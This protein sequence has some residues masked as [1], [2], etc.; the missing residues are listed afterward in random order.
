MHLNYSAGMA[1]AEIL[2]EIDRMSLSDRMKIV[3]HIVYDLPYEDDGEAVAAAS[4]RIE[5]LRSGQ[6]K[7]V[8]HD[9]MM[10]RLRAQFS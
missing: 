7:G 10:A 4:R 1:V 6:V 5:E 8:D 9:Q 3:D 2:S